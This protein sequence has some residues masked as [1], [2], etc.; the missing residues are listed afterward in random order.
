MKEALWFLVLWLTMPLWLPVKI[1]LAVVEV[2]C[3]TLEELFK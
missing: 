1:L 3:I 2:F